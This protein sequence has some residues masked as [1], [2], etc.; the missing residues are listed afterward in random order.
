MAKTKDEVKAA[1]KT[2]TAQDKMNDNIVK[3]IA[4]TAEQNA[5][6]TAILTDMLHKQYK[7]SISQRGKRSGIHLLKAAA[8]LINVD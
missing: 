1:K 8:A 6:Q 2:K 4:Q 7:G 3:L 5:A